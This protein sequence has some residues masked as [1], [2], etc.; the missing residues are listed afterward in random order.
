M[1]I[2]VAT[3]FGSGKFPFA[4]GTAGSIAALPVIW[5]IHTSLGPSAVVAFAVILF[6]IGIWASNIYIEVSGDKDPGPVV[7]DEVVGQAIAISFLPIGLVEYGVAF[8]LFRIFDITKIWPANWA[9]QRL[10][11]GLGVMLDDVVAGLYA[12]VVSL[13]L[14]RLIL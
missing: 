6:F 4:S 5:L 1:A 14:M 3:F 9:E 13:I 11:G 10:P 12:G 2:V 7:I 8:L